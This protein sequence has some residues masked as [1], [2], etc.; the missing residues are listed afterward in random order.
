MSNM[1][2]SQN[3]LPENWQK[4]LANIPAMIDRLC[5]EG[6]PEKRKQ[7]SREC[8]EA[9]RAANRKLYVGMLRN[10]IEQNYCQEDLL[11]VLGLLEDIEKD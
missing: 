4:P 6:D 8:I 1:S 3:L 5:E 10:M 11:L 2:H 7:L 9:H